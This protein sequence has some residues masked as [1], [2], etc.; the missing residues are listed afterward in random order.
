MKK[1]NLL[2][3]KKRFYLFFLLFFTVFF[4]NLFLWNETTQL[5]REIPRLIVLK[6]NVSDE[7]YEI[8]YV[9]ISYDDGLIKDYSPEEKKAIYHLLL[10]SFYYTD[11]NTKLYLGKEKYLNANK[12]DQ[13]N[14]L[15]RIS[16]F[17]LENKF[18]A[19][20]LDHLFFAD[21]LVFDLNRDELE[22]IQEK[23]HNLNFPI[24]F[25]SLRQSF[26]IE[27]DYYFGNFIFGLISSVF[28]M[29]FSLFIIYLIITSSLKIFQQEIRM[30]R[31]M[32]LSKKRIERNFN[33][34][35]LFPI[36]L[37][38][39]LFLMFVQVV[40][41]QPIMIDLTYLLII[42]TFLVIFSHLLI[43]KKVRMKINAE[44]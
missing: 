30:L 1:I 9:P 14:S 25:Y 19:K 4:M 15:T 26:Q 38:F 8:G 18:N 41:L 33:F 36:I 24:V 20:T 23:A 7:I 22:E 17:Q 35:L 27:W 44:S 5:I 42:N 10:D 2:I 13:E 40:G 28:F 3:F 12:K 29:S 31:I 37:I 6:N 16:E 39:P 32:G 34:L 11:K 43:N 21:I